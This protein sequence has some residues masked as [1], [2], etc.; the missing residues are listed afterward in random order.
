MSWHYQVIGTT[1]RHH[2]I[3]THPVNISISAL[4]AS[5]PIAT[6]EQFIRR[7]EHTAAP[8]TCIRI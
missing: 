4:L 1:F 7:Y 5:P 8:N 2:V 6:Y 3:T